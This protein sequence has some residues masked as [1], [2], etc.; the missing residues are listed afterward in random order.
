MQEKKDAQNEAMKALNDAL[1]SDSVEDF[2]KNSLIIGKAVKEE[3]EDRE[4][5]TK[6]K[7]PHIKGLTAAKAFEDFVAAHSHDIKHFEKF[8]DELSD[9]ITYEVI[10]PRVLVE[11]ILEAGVMQEVAKILLEA[12][13]VDIGI[14]SEKEEF[15]GMLYVDIDFPAIVRV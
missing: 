14:E 3:F 9:S 4:K 8:Y 6:A 11:N 13:G 7:A 1:E 5:A 10:L 12:N 2:F 15:A